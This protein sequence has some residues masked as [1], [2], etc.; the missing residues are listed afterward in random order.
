MLAD[1]HTSTRICEVPRRSVNCPG[2][3]RH[4]GVDVGK[5][6]C[7][8]E[9]C[10]EHVDRR[11]LCGLHYS[12]WWHTGDPLFSKGYGPT[13]S[14]VADRFWEKVNKNGPTS[15]LR[16]EL[17]PCWLWT[18]DTPRGYGR[19][20]INENGKWRNL[21][22]HRWAYEALVGPI[23]SDLE[24]DHLCRERACVNPSHLE[25]VA[26]AT[27]T[28][29]GMSPGAIALRRNTCIRGHERTVENVYLRADGSRTCR[30]CHRD[31]EREYRKRKRLAS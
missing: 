31:D 6:T 15:D 8:I 20:H 24:L 16:P 22:A 21:Y 14:D 30:V 13:P 17:G 28:L 18:V 26:H 9:D 5:A 27:N 2:R 29:R 7:S 4:G 11:G 3:G 19:F 23:P 25:A 10:S 12:R 1:A